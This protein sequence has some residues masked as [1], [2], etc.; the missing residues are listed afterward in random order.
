MRPTED[1]PVAI[2]P[3]NP[4]LSMD[5]SL[6]RQQEIADF[7]LKISDSTTVLEREHED[8]EFAIFNLQSQI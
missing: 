8:P 1:F 3:V 4:I 7:R 5:S 6:S 2:P